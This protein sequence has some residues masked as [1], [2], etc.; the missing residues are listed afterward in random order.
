MDFKEDITGYLTAL[1]YTLDKI[2][3]IEIDTVMNVLIAARDQGKQIFVMGNDSSGATASHFVYAFNQNCSQGKEQRF[4][5]ISLNDN[6]PS[7]MAIASERSYDDIFVEQLKNYFL[8]GDVVL[9]ISGTGNSKNVLN[10]IEY[11]NANG[12]LSIGLSGYDGGA[13][14]KIV[15]YSL[16][17]PVD[18]MQITEDV[19]MVFNHLM[20]KILR[21][22]LL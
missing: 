15:K 10:A 4:K 8:P 12:G 14:R 19:H 17:V 22:K 18:D 2:S 7:L 1:K 3:I 20:M 5:F 11:A 13:L 9:G 16:H 6:L 21:A